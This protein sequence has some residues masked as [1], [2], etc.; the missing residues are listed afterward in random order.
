MIL[1][2]RTYDLS[3]TVAPFLVKL[4]RHFPDD[5]RDATLFIWVQLIVGEVFLIDTGGHGIRIARVV[6]K[7]QQSRICIAHHD[8]AAHHRADEEYTNKGSRNFAGW[9]HVVDPWF[10]QKTWT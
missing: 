1:I 6:H 7:T 3:A 2:E 9:K 4:L 10:S 8:K 5:R